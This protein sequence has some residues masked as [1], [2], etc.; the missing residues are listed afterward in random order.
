MDES[1]ADSPSNE[2]IEIIQKAVAQWTHDLIDLGGRNNLL[3]FRDLKLGTAD[4]TDCP[5]TAVS[6]LLQ[7]RV[8]RIAHLFPVAEDRDAA[9]RRFRTIRAKKK[10]NDEERGVD[11]LFVACGFAT[12]DNKRAAW[13]PQAAVLLRQAELKAIGAAQDDFELSLVGEMEVNPT[14]LHVLTSDFDCNFEEES[15]LSQIDGVI[16]EPWELQRAYDWLSAQAKLIPGFSVAPRIVL[17]N[18]AYTKL[19]MVKDLQTGGNQLAAHTIVLAIAGDQAAREALRSGALLDSDVPS[20]DDTPPADEFL[21]LDADATQNY[22]INRALAG[23]SLIVRGPPGTGKSQSISNLIAT[24]MARGK[25]VLFV[26]EKRAAVDAVLKRVDERGLGGLVLNL[27]GGV[28]NRKLFAEEIGRSL[29]ASRTVPTIDLTEHHERLEQR[30]QD[31]NRY[32]QA[33][34]LV[35]DPWG[36]SFYEA[37][38]RLAGIPEEAHTEVRFRGAVGDGLIPAT[39]RQVVDDLRRLI[40][41]GGAT[42]SEQSSPWFGAAVTSADHVREVYAAAES[43]RQLAGDTERA[44]SAA[45]GECGIA[46]TLNLEDAKRQIQ[47]WIDI[48]E[49][50]TYYEASVFGEDLESL[51][52]DLHSGHE[53]IVPPLTRLLSGRYRAA[54]T[55][56]RELTVVGAD[57]SGLLGKTEEALAQSKRWRDANGSVLPSVPT[58]AAECATMLE[59]LEVALGVLEDYRAIVHDRETMTFR[60]IVDRTGRLLDDRS[61]IVNLPEIYRLE[62]ALKGAGLELL[63]E[64]AKATRASEDGAIHAFHYALLQSLVESVS[65]SEPV[66][67]GFSP[68]AHGK[69]LE[70]YQKGDRLHIE[71]TSSR[72]RRLCAERA[73]AARDEFPEQAQVVQRQASLKR[74]HLPIRT[75]VSAAPNVLLALKPC[76]MM[77]P[78]GVSQLLPNEQYFDVVIF[79]EASQV[80]PADAI[81]SISRGSQVV[82]AGDPHQLPPTAFFASGD[83]DP[84]PDPDPQVAVSAGTRGFESILDTLT[85]IIQFRTL[86]WHYRSRDERLIAFSNAHIYDRML[87]TFAG[88]GGPSC[89]EHVL[90]PWHPSADTNSPDPEV[91]VVVDL[92]IEHARER[93]DQSLGVIAMGIKH[94]DRIQEALRQRLHTD[95]KLAQELESFFDESRDEPFFAKNLER[96]QGDER[97]AIILTVGYGKNERGQLVYRFG[98]LLL[99]GGERRLNVAITRAKARLTLVSSFSSRDMDPEKGGVGVQLL[100]QYLQFVE[101]RGE[102]LGD[103]VLQKPALNPFEIDVR[104]T[105][106]ELGLK[107]IPQYG[108]SGYWIDFAVQD[109]SRP[110]SF[111]LAIECDGASYH[112]QPSARDRD[113]LRQEQLERLGW[114]FHRI[115][116]TDWFNNKGRAV[117]AVMRAYQAALKPVSHDAIAPFK[118]AE[119]SDQVAVRATL[120]HVLGRSAPR[121]RIRLGSEISEYSIRDLISIVR[122]VESDGVLRTQEELT[123]EVIKEMGYHRRG[124]RITEAIAR[125]IQQARR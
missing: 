22:A 97:D 87:T 17:A 63:L 114:K 124:H 107:V 77:S 52:D 37:Q 67:G 46:P 111:V 104:D 99:D 117:D 90:A 101:T 9:L 96:V 64:W 19:P 29:E 47:L 32:T 88:V 62:R 40:R 41:I 115:W 110:G 73:V 2:Q 71:A 122:W 76:W 75:F 30:R 18:F 14:L 92:I 3:H 59:K 98:P 10:E 36:V 103:V 80:T 45:A 100:R 42:L 66:I 72:I 27:H 70:E 13:I 21:I 69:T 1:S 89:L 82:V 20:P 58:S 121:P 16:D 109:P 31:L 39:Q 35:R 65:L 43:S 53:G 108:S 23:E 74:R 91:E 7:G 15:L 106:M 93:P 79:D 112:S 38:A 123:T 54:R 81:P 60:G 120:L 85:P 105:L 94:A 116:S 68:A 12:W 4:L 34:H 125:A 86:C 55:R 118:V 83:P 44:L 57:Q 33:L 28:A 119:L 56:L 102:N 24:L 50:L 5:A 84:D 8:V 51:Y 6:S 95:P 113:R 26:A 49:S 78:L 61:T 48:R 25:K 11:T